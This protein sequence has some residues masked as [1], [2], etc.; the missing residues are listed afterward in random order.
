MTILPNQMM[1]AHRASARLAVFC[2]PHQVIQELFDNGIQYNATEVG[3]FL[4]DVKDLFYVY[5]N[6]DG[7]DLKTF[8][9]KYHTLYA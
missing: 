3:V 1:D 4:D 9:N 2:S 7:M 5:D 8:Q 6:G